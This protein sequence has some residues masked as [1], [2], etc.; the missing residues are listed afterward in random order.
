MLN[1]SRINAVFHS[2][3][4]AIIRYRWVVFIAFFALAFAAAAGLPRLKTDVD[5]DKWFMEDDAL[6]AAKDRM[7][8]LF[9]NEDFCAALI[10]VDDVFE[11]ENLRLLRQL[12]DELLDRVPYAD[13]VL[14][15]TDMEFT[16]GVSGGIRIADLV[17]ENIPEDKGQLEAIRRKALSR[18]SLK[19]RL[20]SGDSTETWL[21]LRLKNVP[22][23]VKQ[24]NG[25]ESIMAIGHLFNEIV[26]QPQYTSLHPQATGLPVIS[27]EKLD[28]FNKET[29]RLLG[30]SLVFT[31]LILFFFLRSLRGVVFPL[32]TVFCVM[33]MVFGL[34]GY[35]GIQTDPT[36]IFMPIFITLAVSIG[37]SIHLF[38][39]FND[40]FRKT[41][42]RKESLV[43]AVEEVG[44]PLI[45]S[46][47]TTVAALLS[48]LLIPLRPIRWVGLTSAS[49]VFL[50]CLVVLTL[51]P[52]LLSFGKDRECPSGEITVRE[53][54]M[55][56]FMAWLADISL[57][58]QGL[59]LFMLA[60]GIG[61]CLVGVSRIEV[62]FDVL[63]SFGRKI[64]Y[65]DRIYEVGQSQV[66]SLYS[67]NLALEF[68][69]PGA[70]KD[71]ENLKKF[72][73]LVRDVDKLELTKKTTSLLQIL[74]D[75]NQVMHEGDPEWYRLPESREMVAQLLL[76]YENAGGAEVERWIDYDYQRLKLQV[77]M[78][79]YNSGEAA[80]EL[81]W[82]QQEAGR[83]FP[84]AHVVLTGAISQYT[85]MQEYVSY[86]QIRS[87]FIALVIVTILMMI[88]F[89]SIRIGIISMI[90]NVAPALVVGAI[91]GFA[92]I[93]LDLVTVT[94][95]PMLLGLAVDDT[96]HFINHSQLEFERCGKYV[97][98]NRRTFFAVG[99]A[100]LMTTVVLTLSFSAYMA[101]VV[102]IFVSMGFLVG[103]GLFSA[104]AADFFITPVLLFKTK[105]F[106][107]E[108][109]D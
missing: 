56:R 24:I 18:K 99:G 59:Y 20:V 1:I 58:R 42:R 102:K 92:D 96:I 75:L 106:G 104:L 15:L 29:P 81:K 46:A 9:G 107:K 94:I 68:D 109:M 53:T 71:P 93:P 17:P 57:K 28:F 12:G 62:S 25:E 90:P 22:E 27:A 101:S 35:L 77:E 76:L 63:R 4:V 60:V 10:T 38:N 2:Y 21:I 33:T 23:S 82:I 98:S 40:E 83:L 47:L 69:A 50:A 108:R 70:A 6:L 43:I 44:W 3:G 52:A 100:L 48:F 8:H 72:E 97:E 64:P 67:Y 54:R 37:Y 91:M 36:V 87:F 31:T 5:Q 89:G 34:Q 80:R 61:A 88:V 13:D 49:L 85:V 11:S 32:A 103:A 84:D 74:K 65:V 78:G 79:H 41:G 105:P 45:F 86:G 73:M 19:G 55:Q 14:S 39:H 66:G 7:E 26:S 30:I 51:L 16:E 95:I